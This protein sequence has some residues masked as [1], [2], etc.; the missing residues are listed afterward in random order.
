M[1]DMKY[2][3]IELKDFSTPSMNVPKYPHGLRISLGKEELK[4]INFNG[5]PTIGQILNMEIVVEVVEISSENEGGDENS[6]RVEFQIKEMEIEK[7]DT[8][9]VI[10]NSDDSQI[11]YGV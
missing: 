11:I 10:K 8:E 2:E 3:E 7:D 4:K 1:I 5:V 6:H 9:E